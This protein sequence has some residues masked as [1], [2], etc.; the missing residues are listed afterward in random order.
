[1]LLSTEISNNSCPFPLHTQ[2]VWVQPIYPLF[3]IGEAAGSLISSHRLPLW[4]NSHESRQ[5]QQQRQEEAIGTAQVMKDGAER[6][7]K[8]R[9]CIRSEMSIKRLK[10]R[11]GKRRWLNPFTQRKRKIPV[12]FSGFDHKLRV[13]KTLFFCY[14]L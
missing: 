2:T 5:Q 14:R 13:D 7:R 3:Q 11:S 4:T 6:G 1:M 9:D 8:R 12:T 10:S